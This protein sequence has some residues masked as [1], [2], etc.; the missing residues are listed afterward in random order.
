[1]S[2]VVPGTGR[3][4]N[5]HIPIAILIDCSGSARDI[6]DLINQAVR[7]MIGNLQAK[8]ELRQQVELLAIHYNDVPRTVADFVP[9]CDIKPGQLDIRK[10]E[11]MTNTGLALLDAIQQLQERKALYDGLKEKCSTPM[12][13]LFTD[14]YPDAGDGAPEQYV[15]Q[16]EQEYSEAAQMIRSLEAAGK[17][18]FY[19]AGVQRADGICADMEALRRLSANSDQIFSVRDDT[20]GK[21]TISRFFQLICDAAVAMKKKTPMK[22]VLSGMWD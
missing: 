8:V 20:L 11:R 10:C 9:V 4:P 13:F 17:L 5:K 2:I 12:V 18:Y 22:D 14:G 21:E 16:V 1:M 7:T 3:V 6:Q 15:R 19:A